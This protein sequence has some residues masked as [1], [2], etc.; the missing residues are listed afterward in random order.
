M[1]SRLWCFRLQSVLAKCA[2]AFKCLSPSMTPKTLKKLF[3]E[4]FNYR[5]SRYETRALKR[6]LYP[7]AR[8]LAPIIWLVNKGFFAE[9]LKFIHGLGESTDLD[10]VRV[11]LLDFQDFNFASRFRLRARL[12]L[13]VS[14]R[15]AHELAKNLF[16]S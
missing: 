2:Q 15:K 3:C 12:K 1:P 16:S 7:H 5:E 11:E 8:I 6:C 10:E 14:G 9:D 13:R 4:R